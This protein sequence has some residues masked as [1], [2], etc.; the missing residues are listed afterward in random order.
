MKK[1]LVLLAV[2]AMVGF[3]GSA[4]ATDVNTGTLTVTAQIPDECLVGTSSLAFGQYSYINGNGS[5]D[6]SGTGSITAKCTINS[7]PAIRLG[8]SPNEDPYTNQRQMMKISDSDLLAYNLYQDIGKQT[9][10]L[11]TQTAFG[12]YELRGNGI[13]ELSVPL[14]GTIPQG[15]NKPGGYYTDSVPILVIW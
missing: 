8:A 2:A 14:Y 10:W 6:L 4:M 9:I 7:V 11:S 15:Q 5:T 1:L 13:S 3:A 12:I